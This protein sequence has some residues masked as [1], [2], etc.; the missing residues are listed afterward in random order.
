MIQFDLI[1]PLHYPDGSSIEPRK[2]RDLQEVLVSLFGGLAFF[3]HP[4]QRPSLDPGERVIFRV[5]K[6]KPRP[7]S[8][9]RT[10]RRLMELIQMKWQNICKRD[11]VFLVERNIGRL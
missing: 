11:G 7:T 6:A 10:L 5:T 9:L 8:E 4:Q 2:F 3:P 1:L